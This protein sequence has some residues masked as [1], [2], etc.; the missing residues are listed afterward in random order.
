[1]YEL[2]ALDRPTTSALPFADYPGGG[3]AVVWE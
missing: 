1:L 3:V 2:L